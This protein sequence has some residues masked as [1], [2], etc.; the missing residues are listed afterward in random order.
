MSQFANRLEPQ[1]AGHT[2]DSVEGAKHRPDGIHVRR[3]VLENQQIFV[4]HVEMFLCFSYKI[5]GQITIADRDAVCIFRDV[6]RLCR[7][8]HLTRRLFAE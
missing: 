2:L 3:V 7:Q 1:E 6:F 5:P 4:S 8:G